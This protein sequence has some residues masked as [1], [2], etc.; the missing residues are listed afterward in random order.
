[1]GRKGIYNSK[2]QENDSSA[3]EKV[4]FEYFKEMNEVKDSDIPSI[5][6][7]VTLFIDETL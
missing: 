1:M 3:E 6:H 2:I 5:G 7:F 4:T